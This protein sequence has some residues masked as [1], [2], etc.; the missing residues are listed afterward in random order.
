MHTH[1][2]NIVGSLLNDGLLYQ[3]LLFSILAI[4]SHEGLVEMWVVEFSMNNCRQYKYITIYSY[5]LLVLLEYS[6]NSVTHALIMLT[7][8]TCVLTAESVTILRIVSHG[9]ECD[10]G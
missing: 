5:L 4:E 7:G 9:G 1:E 8:S 10:Q 2:V 3:Q 6:H